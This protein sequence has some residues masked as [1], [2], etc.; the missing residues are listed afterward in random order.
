MQHQ[1]WVIKDRE[2][3]AKLLHNL[4]ELVSGLYD[5]VLIPRTFQRLMIKEDVESVGNDLSALRKLQIASL[6]QQTDWSDYASTRIA[7]SQL[8]S[9]DLRSIEEWLED[10]QTE[11]TSHEE[12]NSEDQVIDT[13]TIKEDMPTKTITVRQKRFYKLW[14]PFP[15]TVQHQRDKH[16]RVPRLEEKNPYTRQCH[17]E[18]IF[19]IWACVQ[20]LSIAG[21]MS[22]DTTGLP[23]KMK[24]LNIPRFDA[25]D[26]YQML[27]SLTLKSES[28]KLS[29]SGLLEFFGL[30]ECILKVHKE[31]RTPLHSVVATHILRR[32]GRS[33][34][35]L[36]IVRMLEY[37][38]Q[39][40]DEEL[41]THRTPSDTHKCPQCMKDGMI[42]RLD[43][44]IVQSDRIVR[45]MKHMPADGDTPRRQILWSSTYHPKPNERGFMHFW[46]L[47]LYG[48]KWV[49]R[50]LPGRSV[51]KF[52]H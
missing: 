35:L 23:S 13:M 41:M 43:G 18:L 46:L 14:R 22:G 45:P 42:S 20:P 6:G 8:A 50:K 9:Q 31:S 48:H 3:F 32:P 39:D 26:C 2:R 36:Q 52:P 21:P 7:A 49:M 51:E 38:T 40:Y 12:H 4:H 33:S 10:S 28:S 37:L 1:K 19:S 30:L 15:Q 17:R 44:E 47:D 11:Y 25:S 27:S 16:K 24:S 29:I 34:V 5:L